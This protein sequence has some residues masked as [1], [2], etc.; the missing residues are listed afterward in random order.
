MMVRSEAFRGRYRSS[1]EKPQPFTP[2]KVE[3]VEFPLQD[4]LHTFKKGH[5]LM[6]QV[7]STWFPLVDRNPQKYVDNIFL[8]DES[9]FIKATHRVHRSQASPTYIRIGVLPGSPDGASH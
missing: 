1:Y 2:G 5:R 6:I 3:V 7:Q 9:D 8:A 4:V